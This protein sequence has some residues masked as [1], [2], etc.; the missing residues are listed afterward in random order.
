MS[1][2]VSRSNNNDL[3]TVGKSF[4]SSLLY[5]PSIQDHLRRAISTIVPSVSNW[6]CN[7][8][9][10]TSAAC[11]KDKRSDTNQLKIFLNLKHRTAD[12]FGLKSNGIIVL[13]SLTGMFD[14][15][16]SQN[17]VCTLHCLDSRDPFT[18][19]TSGSFCQ[20]RFAITRLTSAGLSESRFAIFLIL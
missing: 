10:K 9:R 19:P 1:R 13:I 17:E 18:R 5:L 2:Q 16:F 7:R 15:S 8:N 20:S 12:L 11:F 3:T 14:C 4:D 6:N